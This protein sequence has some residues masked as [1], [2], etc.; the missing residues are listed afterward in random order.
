MP[1][2]LVTSMDHEPP[3]DGDW[4]DDT[5]IYMPQAIHGVVNG[6]TGLN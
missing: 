1:D 6:W 2:N 4:Q 3:K 5:G